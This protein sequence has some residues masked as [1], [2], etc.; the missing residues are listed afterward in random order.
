MTMD[1]GRAVHLTTSDPFSAVEAWYQKELKP[2]KTMR[3]TSTSVVLKNDKTT[4][5]IV[6]ENNLTNILIK[7]SN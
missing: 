2:Q 6:T 1:G 5:T 4:A 3:L 7:V